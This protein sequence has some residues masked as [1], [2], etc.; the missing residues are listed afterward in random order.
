MLQNATNL[1]LFFILMDAFRDIHQYVGTKQAAGKA[2]KCTHIHYII[3]QQIYN[4]LLRKGEYVMSDRSSHKEETT[5]LAT[6]R[7][8][9]REIKF[10]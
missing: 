4:K 3:S 1:D 6:A 2:G 8:D 5:N 10:I 7:H 9:R